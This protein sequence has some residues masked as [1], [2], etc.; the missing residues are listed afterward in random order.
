MTTRVQSWLSQMDQD[1]LDF[2]VH[3]IH[4]HRASIVQAVG[5]ECRP[6]SPL[7]GAEY[8][9]Q[10]MAAAA[11]KVPAPPAET[12]YN[13][14]LDALMLYDS[15]EDDD[16]SEK[17]TDEHTGTAS[18]KSE[19]SRVENEEVRFSVKEGLYCL[20]LNMSIGHVSCPTP[21]GST[22]IRIQVK[23][24]VFRILSFSSHTL[25]CLYEARKLRQ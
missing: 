1:E 22:T 14:V 3:A 25:I 20:V 15:D 18:T 19:I 24:V 12:D 6:D 23:L 17:C 13:H 8:L 9:A 21:F 2:G 5:L 11:S 16:A 10:H 7:L 4:R